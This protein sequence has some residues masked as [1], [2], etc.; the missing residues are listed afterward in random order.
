MRPIVEEY[1]LLKLTRRYVAT[2]LRYLK[3]GDALL[4]MSGP[5]RAKFIR[6]LGKDASRIRPRELG[7]LLD[8]GWRERGTAAWLVAVAGRT[9]FRG[10]L[11][12]LLLASEGPWAGQAYCVALA[13][14][15]TSADTELLVAYLDRYLPRSDLDYDQ[16][17]ALGALLL[18]DARTGTDRAA[19]FLAPDGLWQQWIEGPP[20]KDRVDPDIYR[21]FMGQLCA[22]ADESARHCPARRHG[23]TP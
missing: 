3:L 10:R 7:M 8:R 18:L 23:V 16:T 21:E 1:K 22:F 13:T 17:D 2:D 19:K 12:E 9:E 5:E 20:S 11:G 15:G 6:K 14:F 4:G